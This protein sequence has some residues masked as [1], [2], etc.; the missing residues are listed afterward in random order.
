MTKESVRPRRIRTWVRALAWVITLTG[1]PGAGAYLYALIAGSHEWSRPQAAICL[2]I[3]GWMLPVF[4]FAAV[5]GTAP[6]RWPGFAIWRRDASDSSVNV[7]SVGK[8]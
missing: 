3:L 8:E 6:R 2:F 7:G 5:K 1:V 4:A